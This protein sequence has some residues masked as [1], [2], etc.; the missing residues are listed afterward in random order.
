MAFICLAKSLDWLHSIS[1]P[2]DCEDPLQLDTFSTCRLE[3]LYRILYSL[4]AICVIDTL[5]GL[6]NILS[7]DQIIIEQPLMSTRISTSSTLNDDQTGTQM[8]VEL[9][10]EVVVDENED[11]HRTS[12]QAVSCGLLNLAISQLANFG[13]KLLSLS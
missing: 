13:S 9:P 2:S 5:R 6:L 10:K 1:Q 4:H 11:V 8:Y 12:Q 3:Y 7:L